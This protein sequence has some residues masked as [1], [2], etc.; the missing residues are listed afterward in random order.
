MFPAR[1]LV[2][3]AA[4]RD[5]VARLR[6]YADG[7]Q[8]MSVVKA[9][10]Y[11]HGLVPAARA[12]LAGGASWL[13]V[14]QLSEALALR[15]GGIKAPVLAWLFAPGAPLAQCITA[16]VDLSVS[17]PWALEQVRQASAHVGRPA[18]VHL[19]LDTGLGRGG[20]FFESWTELLHQALAA[21]A[22]GLVHVVGLWSH[23]ARADEVDH[24]S[25]QAQVRLFARAVR[26][27]QTTGAQLEVRHLAN[28]AATITEPGLHYDL[29]RPGLAVYGL[30]P[31]PGT[32]PAQL[33]LRPAMTVEAQV[34]LV[35]RAGAGQGVSYGHTYT[36]TGDTQLALVPI[37]YGD[38]VPRHAGNAAQVM[39]AGRRFRIAGR[40]CMDQFVLDVGDADVAA[41]DRVVLFGPG[42]DGEP[43]AQDWAE[44]AGTI[45]YEIVTRI[46]SRVPR[47]Y[48][49]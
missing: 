19:K 8:V 15:A 30:S 1:V 39:L 32:E 18:R 31:L 25:V 2:D 13:G 5:N 27:A 7:A 22:D 44:A 49:E 38:G 33:G 14:A 26:Y 17:A 46:A 45:N 37:G 40:V 16:D 3:L 24:P 42:S 12:S 11:G 4:I 23:L 9:D 48:S 21:Q 6:E 29:V 41:G 10:G 36:T 35:K 20:A 47:E 34:A 43:T 28:S